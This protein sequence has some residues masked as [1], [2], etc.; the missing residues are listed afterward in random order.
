[1]PSGERDNVQ[2]LKHERGH[3]VTVSVSIAHRWM[4][5]LAQKWHLGSVSRMARWADAWLKKTQL[6][7]L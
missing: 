6:C 4:G 7:S 1:M 5:T 3:M 2:A